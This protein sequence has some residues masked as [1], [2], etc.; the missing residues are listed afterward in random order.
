MTDTTKGLKITPKMC[1]VKCF[2]GSDAYNV[3]MI[4]LK[5]SIDRLTK[6]AEQFE[7][8]TGFRLT[9]EFDLVIPK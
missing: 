5:D 1:G 6:A 2:P 7:Q 4:P 8:A 9:V 3:A